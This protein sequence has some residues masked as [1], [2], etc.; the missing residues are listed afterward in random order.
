ML[1]QIKGEITEKMAQMVNDTIVPG[2]PI[3]VHIDSKGGDLF[4]GLEIF[5][6]LQKHDAEVKIIIDGI[7]GSI[8]S[9]IALAGTSKPSIS[10]TGS[11]VIHNAHVDNIEGNHND[12]RLVADSLEKYSEIVAKIYSKKTKLSNEEALSLMNQETVMSA[13]E[14]IEL[15][16]AGKEVNEIRALSK[17]TKI[18]MKLI[19]KI[20]ASLGGDQ[21]VKDE[22]VTTETVETVDNQEEIET[23]GGFTPEQLQ[24]ITLIVQQ[25]VAEA[26]AGDPMEASIEEKIGNSVA[27]ILNSVVSEGKLPGDNEIKEAQ[28][29]PQDPGIVSFYKEIEKIKEKTNAAN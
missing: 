12:L 28:S 11:I 8:A 17:I 18:N 3:E 29:M 25:V 15:G 14:A 27:T 21:E 16:F 13:S 6:L 19:D 24:E 26:L 4:S 20:M 10:S 23:G 2:E 7:A 1:I 5:N 9:V 22:V